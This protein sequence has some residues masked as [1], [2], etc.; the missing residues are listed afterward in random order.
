MTETRL[1]VFT[2]PTEGREAEY[3]DWYDN[4]HLTD[5]LAIPGFRGAQRFRHR[6]TATGPSAPEE[7]MAIYEI[8]GGVDQAQAA[9]ADAPTVGATGPSDAL[10]SAVTL[11]WFESIGPYRASPGGE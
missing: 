2:K 9:F 4:R 8:E 10:F 11:W 1:I 5:I 3:N 6:P 7:Y